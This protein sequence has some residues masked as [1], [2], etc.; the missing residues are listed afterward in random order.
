VLI[1]YFVYRTLLDIVHVMSSFWSVIDD[2]AEALDSFLESEQ[3][4]DDDEYHDEYRDGYN[5]DEEEEL[6]EWHQEDRGPIDAVRATHAALGARGARLGRLDERMHNMRAISSE[7]AK[8]VRELSTE[9]NST[10]YQAS[11]RGCLC[12]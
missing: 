1:L 12:F 4:E 3:Q 7:T 10:R 11:S 8:L 9:V 2:M 5:G 6:K